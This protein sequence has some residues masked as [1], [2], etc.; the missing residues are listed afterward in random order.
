[1]RWQQFVCNVFAYHQIIIKVQFPRYS[2]EALL[3]CL[4]SSCITANL[5]KILHLHTRY[6]VCQIRRKCKVYNC[7]DLAIKSIR[8]GG[9]IPT[10]SREN[11]DNSII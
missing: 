7:W 3:L 2:S 6:F 10:G 1:M 4:V 8:V 9:T 11:A 5:P